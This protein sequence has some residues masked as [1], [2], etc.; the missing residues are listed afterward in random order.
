MLEHINLKKAF[1][2]G[3]R[4]IL[5]PNTD[6]IIIYCP[7]QRLDEYDFEYGLCHELTEATL[8]LIVKEL[9]NHW[10]PDGDEGGTEPFHASATLSLPRYD[11]IAHYHD[12]LETEFEKGVGNNVLTL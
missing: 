12:Y 3:F 11:F 4:Y 6:E 10:R 1:D 5:N 2:Y 8:R 7:E 9:E